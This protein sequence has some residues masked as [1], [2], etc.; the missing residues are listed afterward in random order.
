MMSIIKYRWCL[1][2]VRSYQWLWI[3]FRSQKLCRR[4]RRFLISQ[5]KRNSSMLCNPDSSM[6]GLHSRRK[7][8]FWLLK[9]ITLSRFILY[10]CLILG[11]VTRIGES[12]LSFSLFNNRVNHDRPVFDA[13]EGFAMLLLDR[14]DQASLQIKI[15]TCTCIYFNINTLHVK[16]QILKIN[17]LTPSIFS[18]DSTRKITARSWFSM[19]TVV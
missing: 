1:V 16:L 10:F 12:L 17:Y 3:D 11:L 15:Y 2:D 8:N 13:R 7:G 19:E 14:K 4:Q 5:E 6:A 18:E 9:V